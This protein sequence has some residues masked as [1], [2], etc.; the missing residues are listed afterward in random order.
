MH[1][2]IRKESRVFYFFQICY[3]GSFNI[4]TDSFPFTAISDVVIANLRKKMRQIFE[5]VYNSQN[6]HLLKEGKGRIK[7]NQGEF[8][9]FPK[10]CFQCLVSACVAEAQLY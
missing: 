6:C 9:K 3:F 8:S 5:F 10:L 7:I 4:L 2:A 1:L